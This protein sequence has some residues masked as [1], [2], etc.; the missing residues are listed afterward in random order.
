MPGIIITI[1]GNATQFEKELARAEKIAFGFS[2]K[3][4]IQLQ[5]QSAA[6]LSVLQQQASEMDAISKKIGEMNGNKMMSEAESQAM[7]ERSR[8]MDVEE[9]TR[10]NK[11]RKIWR[12]RA[13][14]A[15]Q[16]A[17]EIAA[18]EAK[19]YA[20]LYG[21]SGPMD[22][23]KQTKINE[24]L[25][26]K[27]GI[28]G[29]LGGGMAPGFANLLKKESEIAGGQAGGSAAVN[30][31]EKFRQ[32]F[33]GAGS[34]GM[35]QLISVV[36][37]TMSSLGSG[38]SIERIIAQQGPNV[39]QA[40]TTMSGQIISLVL[41]PLTWAVAGS[42]SLIGGSLLLL[43]HYLNK[44]WKAYL[45]WQDALRG[46]KSLTGEYQSAVDAA[47][48]ALRRH[49]NQVDLLVNKHKRLGDELAEQIRLLE[50]RQQLEQQLAQA[51]GKSSL[52]LAR[53]SLKQKEELLRAKTLAKLQL[54]RRVEE[55]QMAY[56]DAAR[57]ANNAG[58]TDQIKNA[59]T[60]EKKFKDFLTAAEKANEA[61]RHMMDLRRSLE[62]QQ[63]NRD[64][65]LAG[66]KSG[67]MAPDP[68]WEAKNAAAI[69][70]LNEQIPAWRNKLAGQ[71]NIVTANGTSI[72][73]SENEIR[74]Q[75]QKFLE[76]RQKL[77]AAQAAL[78]EAET[79]AKSGL[80]ADVAARDR[81][82]DEVNQLSNDLSLDRKFLPKIA[83]GGSK[84]FD[85]TENQR[86]GAFSLASF[87]VLDV[88]KL[89]LNEQRITNNL[90]T[91]IAKK[92]GGIPGYNPRSP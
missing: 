65:Y 83:L 62:Y 60:D 49:G 34:G 41:N 21:F 40:F 5:K 50:K 80:E 6:S 57:A 79:K 19:A 67:K 10:R 28:M 38:M 4:Q 92:P 23:S 89:Q 7:L 53:L 88:N 32:K 13:Q 68:V 63:S 86:H 66:L 2:E 91:D 46:S 73:K 77:E 20:A 35:S 29:T 47:T 37:N 72:D 42:V 64:E 87:A 16:G 69:A 9:A 3:Y 55:S 26:K 30:W 43:Q 39:L 45:N 48:D 12:Q 18:A 59:K 78:T 33:F 70:S 17:Q 36:S 51:Q 31:L 24:Y 8:Q 1:N 90:L 22:A 75:Y 74:A 54:D 71:R 81:L 85:L 82:K 76:T 56:D 52:E 11:A 14:E 44:S 58:N 25:R 27:A 15:K 84:G 61:D